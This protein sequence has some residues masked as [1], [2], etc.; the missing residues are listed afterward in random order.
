MS[1]AKMSL[2]LQYR[3]IAPSAHTSFL[4][5]AILVSVWFLL[6]TILFAFQCQIPKPWV[7]S[8]GQCSTHGKVQ[9]PIIILNI[10][11]DAALAIGLLPTVWN[12]QM[13][14]EMRMSLALLFGSRIVYV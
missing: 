8:P 4:V 14:K 12:L 7:F 13:R 2:V 9:Y 11:S 3:R 5:T 6:S 1:A 10:V